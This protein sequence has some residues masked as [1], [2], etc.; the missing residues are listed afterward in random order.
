MAMS[1]IY[2]YA[3][4]SDLEHAA[5]EHG[6]SAGYDHANYVDAYG[7]APDTAMPERFADVADT[8]T[9]G[10]Q[11]GRDDYAALREEESMYGHDW[12]G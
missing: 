6:V 1:E 9:E 2:R 10:Y 7:E 12:R 5:R 11:E 4:H 3:H 8:W